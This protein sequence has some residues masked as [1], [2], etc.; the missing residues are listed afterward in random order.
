[1]VTLVR[2]ALIVGAIALS[3]I[4]LAWIFGG[5]IADRAGQRRSLKLLK[6]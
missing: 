4:Y 6:G 3:P 2:S 5:W 1:M